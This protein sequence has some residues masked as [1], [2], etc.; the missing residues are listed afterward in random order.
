[1]AVE[2]ML[3]TI[4]NWIAIFGIFAFFVMIVF[5]MFA[6]FAIGLWLLFK[7]KRYDIVDLKRQRLETSA[8][9]SCR[10]G[11]K[12][13]WLYV[14]S[15]GLKYVIKGF[16]ALDWLDP[17]N[18][19]PGSRQLVIMVKKNPA[20]P[21]AIPMGF[22]KMMIR[23]DT[24]D[25]EGDINTLTGD[26]TLKAIDLK[27]RDFYFVPVQRWDDPAPSPPIARRRLPAPEAVEKEE[28][29]NVAQ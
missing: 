25:I 12:N 2:S 8:E 20:L 23:C 11:I 4:L 19:S 26:V 16:T 6:A 5:A 24:A 15:A 3:S 29:E 27:K 21:Y 1:M 17:M 7:R 22:N 18:T 14:G 9:M 13:Q 10:A 28:D